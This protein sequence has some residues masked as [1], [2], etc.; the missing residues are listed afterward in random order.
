MTDDPPRKRDLRASVLIGVLCAALGFGLAVQVQTTSS[1]SGLD[2]ARADDLVRILD[3]LSAREDRLRAE[4]AA[5]EEI[6]DNLATGGDQ[7]A[8]ALEEAL[9]R[10]QQLAILAGTVAAQGPGIELTITDPDAEVGPEV[11]LDAIQEL[12]A[13]GAEAIQIGPVRIGVSSAFTGGPGELVIDGWSVSAPY[14]VL[15]IGD[16][17][18]LETALNIPGGVVNTVGR[19]GG[20]AGIKQRLNVVIDA[21]RVIDDP[22]Y[23]RP[24]PETD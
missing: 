7:A 6:R 13:A 17:P 9:A 21:L 24:A 22:D 15:A 19:A 3:D 1:P 12:R 20:E 18:T 2:T 14:D 16:P 11:L 5:Q 10:E 4:I 8:T 23:A